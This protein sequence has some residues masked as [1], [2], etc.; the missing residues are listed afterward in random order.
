MCVGHTLDQ[1]TPAG[2]GHLLWGLP[3]GSVLSNGPFIFLCPSITSFPSNIFPF[4]FSLN[5]DGSTNLAIPGSIK[6]TGS[7]MLCV[8]LPVCM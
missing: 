6:S 5:K 8:S 2:L 3:P 1:D 7:V 4:L